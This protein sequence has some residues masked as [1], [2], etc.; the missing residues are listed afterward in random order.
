M[1]RQ[2]DPDKPS[3]AGAD[4]VRDNA[5]HTGQRCADHCQPPQAMRSSNARAP[6]STTRQGRGGALSGIDYKR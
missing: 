2:D 3:R 4:M 6:T 1:K 5:G